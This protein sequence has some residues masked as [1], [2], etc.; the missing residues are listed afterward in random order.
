[1][2]IELC[3]D[4]G[5]LHDDG[6]PTLATVIVTLDNGKQVKFPYEANR[7]IQQLYEDIRNKIGLAPAPLNL[8][9]P[10]NNENTQ[11]MPIGGELLRCADEWHTI[12]HTA[13]EQKHGAYP[14]SCPSCTSCFNP[15]PRSNE[16]EREDIVECVLVVPR[17]NG[18]DD[19]LIPKIGSKYRVIAL[20]KQNKV[21]TYY[22]VLD[23][24]ADNKIRMPLFPQEVK[25]FCKAVPQPR[26]KQVFEITKKCECGEVVSLEL[27]GET[28]QGVCERCNGVL[29]ENKTKPSTV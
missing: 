13:Y 10:F 26:R 1:M 15:P 28:Y 11:K 4:N 22:E 24:K 21:L 18:I 17:D 27:I 8:P 16:I 14:R 20:I 2:K 3:E 9:I 29:T 23:D 19:D 5:F 6:K 12:G 7:M 25:L